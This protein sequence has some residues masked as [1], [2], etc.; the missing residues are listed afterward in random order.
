MNGFFSDKLDLIKFEKLRNDYCIFFKALFCCCFFYVSGQVK[1][2]PASGHRSSL[3]F[4]EKAE[5]TSYWVEER[6]KKS[7]I[8]FFKNYDTNGYLGKTI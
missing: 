5:P 7:E 2:H 3:V 4:R 6:N 8:I 1:F